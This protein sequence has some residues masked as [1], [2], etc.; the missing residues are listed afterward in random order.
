MVARIAARPESPESR[1]GTYG[2][3]GHA[4]P[5]AC[6]GCVNRAD[7]DLS[8]P[9]RRDVR[10]GNSIPPQAAFARQRLRLAEPRRFA[11]DAGPGQAREKTFRTHARWQ[12]PCVGLVCELGKG[13]L[14]HRL[15]RPAPRGTRPEPEAFQ[16]VF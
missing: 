5:K 13:T 9:S 11:R 10:A 16:M 15:G 12:N 14:P 6:I 8:L 3:L 7:Y 1:N 4:F 2:M